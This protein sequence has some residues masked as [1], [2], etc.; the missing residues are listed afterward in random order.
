MKPTKLF[1]ISSGEWNAMSFYGRFEQ[2]VTWILTLFIAVIIA[3]A[4]FRLVVTIFQKLVFGALNPLN[5]EDFE[6]I[7]G[8]IMTLLIT[9]EFNHSIVQAIERLH[10]IIQVKTVVLISILALARKFIILNIEATSALTIAAL[11]FAAIALGF[12]YWL[13]R[14]RDDRNIATQ[15][16]QAPAAKA[17]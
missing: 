1:G 6:V 17:W 5:H 3:I 2:I 13:L 4:L 9:M 8:M 12:V 14:E 11:A 10:R 15:S 16:K 7:F